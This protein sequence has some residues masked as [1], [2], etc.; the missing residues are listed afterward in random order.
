MDH[1]S[2][3]DWIIAVAATLTMVAAIAALIVAWRAPQMAAQFAEQLRRDDAVESDRAKLRMAIFI[4]LMKSRNQI[5][6]REA[7]DALNLVDV[8]FAD[9]QSVRRA[10]KSFIEATLEEPSQPVKIVE[11]YH[12]LIDKVAAEVGFSGSIGPSDIQSGYY[13]RGLG[14]LDEAALAEAEEKIARAAASLPARVG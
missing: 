5:L 1:P 8:V 13:P 6:H 12:A 14:K 10:R 9:A 11:R 3:T 2:I 4:S 7:I